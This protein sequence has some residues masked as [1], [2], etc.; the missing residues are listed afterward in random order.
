[1]WESERSD[2]PTI[3]QEEDKSNTFFLDRHACYLS[4]DALDSQGRIK[5]TAVPK[6]MLNT[7]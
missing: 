4:G 6:Q 3:R 7:F 1:M 5:L 2:A